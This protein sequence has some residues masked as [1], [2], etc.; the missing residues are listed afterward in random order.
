MQQIFKQ[1]QLSQI[2][3]ILAGC[4]VYALGLNL[5]ILPLGLYSGGVVGLAQ[6]LSLMLQ[7]A[8][9]RPVGTLNLYGLVHF[10]LNIPI[11]AIA[12]L[13]LGKSF[14][15]KTVIGTVGIS[16]FT[17]VIPQ[18]AELLAADPAVAIVIGGAVTGLGIGIMLTAGGSGGGIEVLGLWLSRMNPNFT[19]GR[20]TSIFNAALFIV[21]FFKFDASTVIYSLLYMVLY[22]VSLDKFHYQNINARITV[23]T[24]EPGIDQAIMKE[25]G[26]GVTEWSGCGAFTREDSY[27]LVTIISKYEIDEVM[28]IIHSI[29]GNAFIVI[30]EGVR[31]FGNFQRR[32]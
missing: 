23:F 32:L 15:F 21:Y 28:K 22:T 3:R 16:V 13:K 5:F 25:M 10:L 18:P 2:C 20:M 19:V 1:K 24:K 12:Q 26:R 31:V 17:T 7:N 27:I 8:L 4:A 30:D 29:D 14:L 6:L 9:H 11:L